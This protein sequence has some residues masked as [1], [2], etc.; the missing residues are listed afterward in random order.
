MLIIRERYTDAGRIKEAIEKL[1]Q[2]GKVLGEMETKKLA[3]VSREDYEEA[4]KVKD[5]IDNYR[6]QVSLK[7]VAERGLPH[8][9]KISFLVYIIIIII[10]IV[11]S[12][13]D[14]FLFVSNLNILNHRLTTSLDYRPFYFKNIIDTTPNVVC[15]IPILL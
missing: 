11:D 13:S 7:Y 8:K 15:I 14:R 9:F 3:A 1:I 10:I 5:E 4:Q 2:H 12:T 6:N